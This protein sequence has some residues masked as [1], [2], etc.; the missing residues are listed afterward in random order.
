[1]EEHSRKSC[2]FLKPKL[3]KLMKI[4]VCY[5]SSIITFPN[6]TVAAIQR[7]LGC[8]NVRATQTPLSSKHF[9][10]AHLIKL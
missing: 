5:N 8:F 7:P 2:K 3:L 4:C 1:M 9:Q 6:F 10:I